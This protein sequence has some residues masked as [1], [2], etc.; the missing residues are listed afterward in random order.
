MTEIEKIPLI[1]QKDNSVKFVDF[2]CGEN[3]MLIKDSEG[4]LWKTGLKL[5]YTPTKI[6]LS[7]QNKPKQFFSGRSFY[8]MIDNQNN[9]Y[10]WGNLFNRKSTEDKGD[11]MDMVLIKSKEI[12]GDL[13]IK[14]I[15]SKF[16][17][18]GALLKEKL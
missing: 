13:E 5:D 2:T 18:S 11:E 16:T 8:C 17:L 15:S 4:N 3:T 12:F 1:V 9:V 14:E 6:E 10:Q 7:I